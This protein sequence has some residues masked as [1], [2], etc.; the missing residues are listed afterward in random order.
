MRKPKFKLGECV[1]IH[2][3]DHY[4]PKVKTAWVNPKDVDI[5]D[6]VLVVMGWVVRLTKNYVVVAQ[7]V[8]DGATH[9]AVGNLWCVPLST[10]KKVNRI[11]L[12]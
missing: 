3:L 5:N 10:I 12:S 11:K 2:T 7:S 9:E 6:A 4:I 8:E 1:A